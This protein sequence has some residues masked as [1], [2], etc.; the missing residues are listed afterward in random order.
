M[1]DEGCVIESYGLTKQYGPFAAVTNLTFEVSPHRITGFLGRNGAG[2]STTIK[3]LLGDSLIAIFVR[4]LVHGHLEAQLSVS[5]S[6]GSIRDA[7]YAGTHPASTPT[8]VNVKAAP[9]RISGSRGST[10]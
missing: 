2:K 10:P 7:R 4:L 5:T 6:A 1:T 8:I 3:M 9:T